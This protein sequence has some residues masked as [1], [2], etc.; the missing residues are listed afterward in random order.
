MT[1]RDVRSIEI[2]RA[3]LSDAVSRCRKVSTSL[4]MPDGMVTAVQP[5]VPSNEVEF[6]LTNGS[7]TAQPV[8]LAT[9]SLGALAVAYLIA[10]RVPVPK[11]ATKSISVTEHG[12]RL[13]FEFH[14][15][16]PSSLPARP[17]APLPATAVDWR[18]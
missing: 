7:G 17:A 3:G 2:D 11:Q 10:V 6:T 13:V 9:A 1:I 16:T 12:V 4:G 14:V 5:R 18:T 15:P 8:V